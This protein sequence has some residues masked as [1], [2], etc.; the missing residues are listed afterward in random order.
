MVNRRQ[1][2][3]I[4]ALGTASFAAPLAYSASNIT[5]AYNT[6][7]AI[8]SISPKDLSDNARNLDYLVN[9][10]NAL[11]PDRKGILRKSWKGMEG[12][13]DADQIRR[14]AEF[15]ADQADRAV[16]FHD[17]LESS[18]FEIP[19]DYVAGLGI[20]RP[21]QVVRF[22]GELY[23]AHDANLPFTTTTWAADAAK[24][25]SM[26]DAS[27]RQELA[28]P[29]NRTVAWTRAPLREVISSVHQMLD[30]QPRSIWEFANLVTSRPTPADPATWDWTPAFM[31]ALTAGGGL[32]LVYGETYRC[33]NL[34]APCP[35]TLRG[36]GA[37]LIVN[38]VRIKT[39][40]F[41]AKDIQMSPP[42]YLSTNRG[43]LCYAYEDAIDYANITIEDIHF[44]GFYYSTDFRARAYDATTADPTNRSIKKIT[45][46]GCVSTAPPGGVNAAHFQ[47][48]G[49][50]DVVTIGNSSHGG[51]GAA[52]YNY[53]NRNSN[54]KCIG[55][56]DQNNA[57][58]SFELENS[59]ASFSIVEGNM[60]GGDL[61]IDDTSNVSVVGNSVALALKVTSQTI[62][63]DNLNITGNTCGRITCT[64]FGVSPTE[65]ISNLLISGNV[66]RNPT[67]QARSLFMDDFV[68]SARVDGNIFRA[69]DVS[70]QS[71]AISVD[72]LASIIMTNNTMD[73]SVIVSG[74]VENLI[75]YGNSSAPVPG[76]G[77]IHISRALNPSSVYFDL[78]GQ[79]MYPGRYSGSVV[80]GGVYT[81]DVAIP[82]LKDFAARVITAT[83]IFR[84]ITASTFASFKQDIVISKIGETRVAALSTPYAAA[85]TSPDSVTL[86]ASVT[87]D[88]VVSLSA[89]ND[90]GTTVQ[91]GII[92]EV[93]SQ[94]TEIS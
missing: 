54:V 56:Y 23:R 19:V 90:T 79:Y 10:E 26:G 59:G 44:S 22:G 85:G 83:V 3:K 4:S 25:F 35:V 21:T 82:T 93:S 71:V 73:G 30:A 91:I 94:L 24:F 32:D 15:D 8:G 75:E 1:L 65:K 43:F 51:I 87:A 92:L 53:I 81:S 55:N 62:G 18:G 50:S 88:S 77:A 38:S 74:N 11:Y 46:R 13:H 47:H 14:E 72:A 78:P 76:S 61:W 12:E 5:M 68:L 28:D 17:F 29:S 64:Q 70:N 84:N 6:G 41:T 20:T 89:T 34:V 45:V 80:I 49:C 16:E 33:T 31:A 52:S 27:I 60:F 67:L 69:K 36:E 9:G 63:V 86:S 48:V 66:C 58:A 2:L 39:S 40:N 42:S 37:T 7:N 57:Y